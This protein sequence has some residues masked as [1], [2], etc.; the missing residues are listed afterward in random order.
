MTMKSPIK[1]IALIGLGAVGV[2]FAYDMQKHLKKGQLRIVADRNRLRRYQKDG[3][4]YNDEHCDFTYVADDEMTSAADLVLFCV[5]SYSLLEAIASMKHQI[6]DHTLVMSA[7]NGITS[8]DI[9]SA[10]FP[11]A[12]IIPT[13]A[14]GMDATKEGNHVYAQ[15]IGELCFG[16]GDPSQQE[17]VEQIHQFFH[18]IQ[19]PHSVKADI[20]HHQWGKFMLNCGLNQVC[21]L[22]HGTYATIQQE[23]AP[24]E[25]MLK[26]MKEVQKL[27]QC[28]DISLS[29]DD[30]KRWAAMCDPL[31]PE[32]MPSM[33][34]DVKAQRPMETDLF[35]GE[36]CRMAIQYGISCPINADLYHQ[37]MA[38]E[39]KEKTLDDFSY[40]LGVMDA[41]CEM[42]HAHVK[43]LALSHP[44]DCV[45]T[46]KQYLPYAQQLS[47]QYGI[48]C[49][50]ERQSFISDLFPK[51]LNEGKCNIIFYRDISVYHR[52]WALKQQKEELVFK[53]RYQGEARIQLAYAYGALLGYDKESCAAKIS[54]NH[55]KED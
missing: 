12:T 10:H 53:H 4:Y 38:M 46:M 23:G 1:T 27:A 44:F 18:E 47:V 21:A 9:L 48:G 28:A 51:S 3:I 42:V 34:Q 7:V 17:T 6:D 31:N 39:L 13:V 50:A 43:P 19:F 20:V 52:Y 26:A 55:D 54:H 8:E 29:D 24:R 11:D 33:A 22:H 25:Q 36:V 15:N 37:L 40:Q 16:A 49:F 14:Q 45:E 5:K 32:G 2:N 41:F 35:S 30:V